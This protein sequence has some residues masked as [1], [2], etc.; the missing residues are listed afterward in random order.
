MR[1]IAN[2]CK[3][4]RLVAKMSSMTVRQSMSNLLAP[5]QHGYGTKLGAEARA[6]AARIYLESVQLGHIF[7]KPNFRTAFNSIHRE[8]ILTATKEIAP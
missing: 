1:L 7:L 3:L 8:E 6:H 4:R 2:R 5:S